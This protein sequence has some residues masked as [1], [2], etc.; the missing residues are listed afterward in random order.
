[1]SVVTIT[2]SPIGTPSSDDDGADRRAREERKLNAHALNTL[3]T[4]GSGAFVKEV[5]TDQRTSAPMTYSEMRDRY[6]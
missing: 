4:Q 6:G 3:N 5:F 2:N 1:M